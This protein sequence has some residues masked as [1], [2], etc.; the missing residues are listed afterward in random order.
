M[1]EQKIEDLAKRHPDLFEKSGDFEFSIGDGWYNIIDVLCGMLS[2]RVS[3]AKQRL[4][5]AMENPEAKFAKPILELEKDVADALEELPTFVQIKEKFGT[6]RFYV[7]GGTPEMHNYIEFAE[8]MTSC[9]CEECGNPG[10]SRSGGWVRVLCNDCHRKHYPN[11]YPDDI[12]TKSKRSPKLSDE[13]FD[14]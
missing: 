4:K 7:H 13:M 11:E 2:Y 14:E 8:A 9:T 12:S 10:K 6:L 5:Y 3:N 1:D